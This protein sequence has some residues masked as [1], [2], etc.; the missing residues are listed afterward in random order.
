MNTSR[1]PEGLYSPPPQQG[2]TLPP[3]SPVRAENWHRYHYPIGIFLVL[4]GLTG[5]LG[6]LIG[7]SDHQKEMANYLTKT[8]G[9]NTGLATPVL[10]GLHVVEGLLILITLAG[11]LRRRD[12]WFLPVVFGW[13]AG[14]AVFCVLDVWAGTMSRLAEHGV[15]LIGFTAV[16]LVSYTLG[17]KA[18]VGQAPPSGQQRNTPTPRNLSRTQEIA[19][20]ALNRWQRAAPPGP[21]QSPAGAQPQ[22]PPAAQPSDPTPAPPPAAAAAPAPAPAPPTTSAPTSTPAPDPTPPP[23]PTPAPAPAPAPQG[24]QATPLPP[25]RRFPV[26]PQKQP[27]QD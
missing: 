25:P 16:L 4:Y 19:L 15:Y 27:P 26:T 2:Q 14:F 5:L 6:V 10:A 3:A 7:W 12:V 1:V 9:L 24:Q 11:L 18:R 23:N 22:T 20:S 13:M 8:A 17:V 21:V